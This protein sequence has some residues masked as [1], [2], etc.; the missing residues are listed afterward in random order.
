[1]EELVTQGPL[2]H[3]QDERMR[4]YTNLYSMIKK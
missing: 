1:M 4:D 2:T 3:K